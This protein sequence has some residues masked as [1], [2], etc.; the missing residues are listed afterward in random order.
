ME[1]SAKYHRYRGEIPPV[2]DLSE[3]KGTFAGNLE[4]DICIKWK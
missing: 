2:F 3:E 4:N 1:T